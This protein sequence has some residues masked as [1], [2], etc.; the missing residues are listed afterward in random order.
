MAVYIDVPLVKY[1][2]LD[3]DGGAVL[4]PDVDL[5]YPQYVLHFA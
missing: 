1:H 4:V 2:R 5:A 3:E